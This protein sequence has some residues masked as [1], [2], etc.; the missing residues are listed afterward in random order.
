LIGA[1][2]RDD[3]S[4]GSGEMGKKFGGHPLTINND[5]SNEEAIRLL[6]VSSHD[7]RKPTDQMLIPTV[8]G[9]QQWMPAF[10]M[11]ASRVLDIPEPHSGAPLS[12]E[13]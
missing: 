1:Q 6:L 10:V 3:C 11:R 13:E 4:P 9:S 5:T 7:G 2:D 12:H 8:G